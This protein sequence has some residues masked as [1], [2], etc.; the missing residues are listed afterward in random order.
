MTTVEHHYPKQGRVILHID[1]NAFYC[2]VHEAVEPELY[3]GK[4]I[5]VAGSVE[6]R[7]GSLLLPLMLHDRLGLGRA[8]R[9]DKH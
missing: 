2:S 5:A 8:C 9:S 3:K 4:P 6:L 7:R 1:M